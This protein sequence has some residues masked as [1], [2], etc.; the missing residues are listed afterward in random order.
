MDS[1]LGMSSRVAKG[2]VRPHVSTSG[3]PTRPALPHS[4]GIVRLPDRQSLTTC[5]GN[6]ARP[7]DP[8]HTLRESRSPRRPF[9]LAPRRVTRPVDSHPAVVDPHT[10][11]A[12]HHRQRL[13]ADP[14]LPAR[15]VPG[16]APSSSRTDGPP[17]GWA[18][19][20]DLVRLPLGESTLQRPHRQQAAHPPLQAGPRPQVDHPGKGPPVSHPGRRAGP[21]RYLVRPRLATPAQASLA[22]RRAAHGRVSA[23]QVSRPAHAPPG[24][25]TT[26]S[27]EAGSTPRMAGPSAAP[28]FPEALAIAPRHFAPRLPLASA[29]HFPPEP[30]ARQSLLPSRG[31]SVASLW[32]HPRSGP[33]EQGRTPAHTHPCHDSYPPG[34][35][36]RARPDPLIARLSAPPALHPQTR[37]RPD[38]HPTSSTPPSRNCRGAAPARTLVDHGLDHSKYPPHRPG[39]PTAAGS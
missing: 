33:G 14:P 7:A 35:T 17:P 39:T 12:R 29:R 15:G 2:A 22:L 32:R 36:I 5:P 25:R 9:P 3:K 19:R 37:H 31:P 38:P 24:P 16:P 27:P 11:A 6:A 26:P 8:P 21:R 13:S 34:T 23:T 1:V 30:S 4:F 18:R 20:F 28:P 10:R